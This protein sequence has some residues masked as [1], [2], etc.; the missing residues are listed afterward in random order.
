MIKSGAHHK[1]GT[2]SAHWQ[3]YNTNYFISSSSATLIEQQQ[4]QWRILLN[5]FNSQVYQIV[6]NISQGLYRILLKAVGIVYKNGRDDYK[7]LNWSTV[8]KLGQHE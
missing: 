1:L 4:E 5:V 3:I 8:P 7:W 6:V 2:I